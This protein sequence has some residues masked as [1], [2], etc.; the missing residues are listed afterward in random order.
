MVSTRIWATLP[1][2]QTII[3]IKTPSPCGQTS[4]M[5]AGIDYSDIPDKAKGCPGM[6][7]HAQV[8]AA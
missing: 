1:R 3:I 7:P 4:A 8:E 2:D 6:A 5:M